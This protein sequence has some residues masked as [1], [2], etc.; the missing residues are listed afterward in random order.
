MAAL[1]LTFGIYPGSAVGDAAAAGPP[2][3]PDRINQALDQLQGRAARPFIVRACDHRQPRPGRCLPRI[4]EALIAGVRT[5]KDRARRSG[6]P[7]LKVG[8][9]S[10]PLLGPE[11]D[12]FTDL[13]RAGGRAVHRRPRLHRPRLLP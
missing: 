2:D 12:F 5:A 11:A 3:R 8:C 9:N 13:T 7:G 10:S 6:R 1:E 4:T